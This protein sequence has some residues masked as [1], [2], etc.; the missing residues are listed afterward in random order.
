MIDAHNQM[1]NNQSAEK[2]SPRWGRLLIWIGL[3]AFLILLFFGLLNSQKSQIKLG[4]K[5]PSFS[6]ITFQGDKISSQDLIGKVV[7]LNLWASWCKPCEQ[8]AVDLENAWRFYKPR[9][10]VVFLGVAWTDTDKKSFEYLEKFGITYPNGPD[11]GTRIYQAFRATGVPETY[12][13]DRSG[14]LRHIKVSPFET[15]AEIQSVVDL[16]LVE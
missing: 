12:I 3:A 15:L 8:E 2:R 7:V 5:A 16:V 6:L 14:I 9:G 13:I 11:L 1:G 4:E 10:D